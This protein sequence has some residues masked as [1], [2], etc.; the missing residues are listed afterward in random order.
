MNKLN[1]KTLP[2]SSD[3]ILYHV[4]QD[5]NCSPPNFGIYAVSK[6]DSLDQASINNR[7]FTE[8]EAV[9]CCK[10]LAE[11]NVYPVTIAEVLEDLFSL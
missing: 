6:N 1:N 2:I 10:W 7:F 5:E 4:T 3:D 9:M 8:N 11:N